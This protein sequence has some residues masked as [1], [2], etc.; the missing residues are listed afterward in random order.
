VLRHHLGH[1]GQLGGTPARSPKYPAR[2]E[3]SA[4]SEILCELRRSGV[5]TFSDTGSA[6]G[7][8]SDAEFLLIVFGRRHGGE[9][10]ANG[11]TAIRLDRWTG[12]IV[13]CNAPNQMI[14][15]AASL[16]LPVHL[17]CSDVTQEEIKQGRVESNSQMT[18]RNMRPR[19][20]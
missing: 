8:R 10:A 5:D 12:A 3:P 19:R 1:L 20:H 6:T 7:C 9:V 17:R 4:R 16:G 2:C 13:G 15:N 11:G 18:A 14:V